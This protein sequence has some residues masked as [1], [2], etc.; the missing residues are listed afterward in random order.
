MYHKGSKK[1][2]ILHFL[3]KTTTV[4]T[5]GILFG[6]VGKILVT[7]K[8]KDGLGNLRNYFLLSEQ[9]NHHFKYII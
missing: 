2:F 7:D 4:A 8:E 9:S 5:F 1:R 3:F 6:L